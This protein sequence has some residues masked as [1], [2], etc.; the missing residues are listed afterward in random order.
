MIRDLFQGQNELPEPRLFSIYDSDFFWYTT[1]CPLHN[2]RDLLLFV[3]LLRRSS[4]LFFLILIFLPQF[5]LII[6]L[7]LG[8]RRLPE[9][10]RSVNISAGLSPSHPKQPELPPS[11]KESRLTQT[12]LQCPHLIVQRFTS[13][14]SCSSL[15]FVFYSHSSSSLHLQSRSCEAQSRFTASSFLRLPSSHLF[16]S[17]PSVS[18]FCVAVHSTTSSFRHLPFPHFL[19]SSPAASPLS[20]Q[21]RLL[22]FHSFCSLLRLLSFLPP[23]LFLLN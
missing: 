9:G 21:C 20:V 22:A 4:R 19:I 8:L 16:I 2:V 11:E 10:C 3:L 7:R 15:F 5:L 12:V 18:F 14:F 13:A 1:R 6:L 23:L 17:S